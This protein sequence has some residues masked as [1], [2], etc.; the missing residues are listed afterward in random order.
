MMIHWSFV[1]KWLDMVK[2]QKCLLVMIYN[3]LSW[4]INLKFDKK[5]DFL[6]IS[7]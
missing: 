4:V 5:K 1:T 7:D 6:F 2:Q 3:S